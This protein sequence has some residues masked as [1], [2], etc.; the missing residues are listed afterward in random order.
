MCFLKHVITRTPA[1][2]LKNGTGGE[3]Q[4]PVDCPFFFSKLLILYI[5]PSTDLHL[6]S[7]DL[8]FYSTFWVFVTFLHFEPYLY[9]LF[10]FQ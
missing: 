2:I 9:L 10:Y 8:P 3:N 6:F 5:T 1:H 4:K 7:T